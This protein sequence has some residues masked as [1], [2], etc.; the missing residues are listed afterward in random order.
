MGYNVLDDVP[1]PDPEHNLE[2]EDI[3][4]ECSEFPL[5]NLYVLRG[6][7]STDKWMLLQDLSTILKIKSKDALLKQITQPSSPTTN[8]KSVLKEMKMSEFLEQAICCQFLN[9]NEKIN[10]RASKVA[11]VRYTDK[12]KQLLNVEQVFITGR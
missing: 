12:V 6:E 3:E 8:N 1:E 2:N 5:P 11:L 7:P 9:G 4:I 10:T